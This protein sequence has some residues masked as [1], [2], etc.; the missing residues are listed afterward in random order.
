MNDSPDRSIEEIRVA[1]SERMRMLAVKFLRNARKGLNLTTQI[2][3]LLLEAEWIFVKFNLSSR[4]IWIVYKRGEILAWCSWFSWWCVTICRLFNNC[5]QHCSPRRYVSW[6]S[7]RKWRRWVCIILWRRLHM[8]PARHDRL[9][10]GNQHPVR[11]WH[12]IHL[13][14]CNSN[15]KKLKNILCVNRTATCIL[16]PTGHHGCF[17]QV[18]L[19]HWHAVHR[20]AYAIS[21]ADHSPQP[22][23]AIPHSPQPRCWSFFLPDMWRALLVFGSAMGE[24]YTCVTILHSCLVWYGMVWPEY[25]TCVTIPYSHRLIPTHTNLY[26]LMPTHISPYQLSVHTNS[27]QLIPVLTDS[28]RLIPTHTNS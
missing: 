8:H 2:S 13:H 10:D 12:R 16:V 4:S 15:S 27:Y 9:Y 11:S 3:L 20:Q 1:V 5:F 14:G 22:R 18:L 23:C 25:Y 28:Y 7:L 21:S 6:N 19:L 24:H 17:F 26:Q